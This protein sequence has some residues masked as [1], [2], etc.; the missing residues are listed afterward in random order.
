MRKTVLAV[1]TMILVLSA[2][3]QAEKVEG[4]QV[5]YGEQLENL[6]GE[7][8]YPSDYGVGR[9]I[10]KKA[11]GGY[12]IFDY[13]SESSYR[14]LA[15]SSNIQAIEDNKIYIKYPE[16]VFSD[17]TVVFSYSIL[18]YSTD[19]VAVY[20]GE[21]SPEDARFLYR[22]TR[23]TAEV[24]K[25]TSE[26]S[27]GENL[28]TAITQLALTYEKFNADSVNSRD[29]RETFIAKFIQN[30]RVSFDYL[31][32]ISDENGGKISV[33]ELNYM[34]YSLTNTE[35]DFS[36]Y[37]DGY[38]DRYDTAS[39]LNYGRI[40][41]YDFEC[42]DDDVIVTAA[43]EVGYDGTESVHEYEITAELIPNHYSCFDGYSVVALSSKPVVS[44]SEPDNSAHTFYG[45]DMM[46]ENNGVFV[47]ELIG[48]EDALQYRHFV[49][50]DLTQSPEQADFVRENAGKS[51][52]ITFIWTEGNGEDIERI[53]PTEIVLDTE[54]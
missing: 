9:L 22:A 40:T 13:E 3:G 17:D 8:E 52:K 53:V 27:M 49:Y 43:F 7:Y 36:S 24:A 26:F 32:S 38:I 12:D 1:L 39:F 18:E 28:K 16:A 30:A 51:F 15:N 46:E 14:F 48:A 6:V 42:K 2:C 54:Q 34:Q 31:D 4:E 10:I 5:N 20:Y 41:G 35:V 25:E 19:E 47:F 45:T 44:D 21:V 50:A 11:D 37:V 23:K 33:D 29:W